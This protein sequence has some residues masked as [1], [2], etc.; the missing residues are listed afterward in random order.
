MMILQASFFILK[1]IEC[2]RA[3]F[4]RFE[5]R[6]LLEVIRDTNIESPDDEHDE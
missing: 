1:K 4:E 2:L 3:K 5:W 6:H